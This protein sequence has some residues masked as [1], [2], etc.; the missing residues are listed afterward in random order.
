MKWTHPKAPILSHLDQS[1]STLAR[2]PRIRPSTGTALAVV[3]LYSIVF[4]VTAASS[5]IPYAEFF[6]SPAN[7]WRAAVLPLALGTVV[8]VIFLLW[9][10]WDH[11]FSDKERLG[12]PTF[13]RIAAVAFTVGIVVH[14]VFVGW[15]ELRVDLLIPILIT[16]ILVGFSEELLFR[17]ILLQG[18]RAAGRSEAMVAVGTSVIFGLFHLTNIF[19]GSPLV[20]V[21]GQVLIATTTG[22]I[23]Y[24]F[25]RVSG[26]LL[27]GIIAHGLWD[28]SVFLP[29]AAPTAVSSL[30]SLAL[31]WLMP[32]IGVI[33]LIIVGIKDRRTPSKG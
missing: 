22:A 1:S 8:L 17:G 16:G 2:S 3:A 6:A 26:L 5:G 12:V 19:L 21:L 7:A 13:L 30:S 20:T 24:S 10:R 31:L 32:T 18:M 9:S 23:L 33:A 28:I 15:S 11:I 14:F 27:P 4:T 25:R 29:P